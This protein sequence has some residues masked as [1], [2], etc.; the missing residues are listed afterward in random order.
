MTFG[1]N[2]DSSFEEALIEKYGCEV[3]AY[4]PTITCAQSAF[5]ASVRYI[6]RFRW[7]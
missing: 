7:F 2:E 6:L 1:I 5:N 4:D 3:F